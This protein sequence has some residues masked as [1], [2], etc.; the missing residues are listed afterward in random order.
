MIQ[1]L[2]A[3]TAISLVTASGAFAA[4]ATDAATSQPTTGM[5]SQAAGEGELATAIIG[6]TVY[7]S[8]AKEESVGDVNDL[9]VADD[10]TVEAVVIGVGGFLNVG[11]KNVAVS[12]DKLRWV[13]DGS[14]A[15]FAVLETSRED[16]ENAPEFTPDDTAM[17]PAEKPM[18]QA[19]PADDQTAMAPADK[20][21]EHGDQTAMAPADNQ[22]EQGGQVAM[23]PTDQSAEPALSDLGTGSLSADELI[24][25]TVYA[26][27]DENVGEV[28]D[29]RLS[30]K[31]NVDAVI[32]DVGGFL[33]I[34]EKPVAIAFESLHFK[35]DEAGTF[36][37]YTDFARDQLE[38]AP[39]YDK[40]SY[41]N[42]R[43]AMRLTQR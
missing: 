28:G 11:E 30:T 29:V 19:E 4:G 17:A 1:K 5:Y 35:K 38:A 39:T 18:N 34:G 41:D 23:A 33:G 21:A 25:A 13:T 20:Q 8:D 26:V 43:E 31:G 24:G 3:A 22:A 16:L 32:V 7:T 15:Q 9:I 6:Q 40:A 36:Y 12:F 42:E 14:G 27:D 10:G 2:L 37:V